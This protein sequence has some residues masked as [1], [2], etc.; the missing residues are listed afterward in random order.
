M[1]CG[2]FKATYLSDLRSFIKSKTYHS[3]NHLS[4]V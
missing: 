3:F 4:H 1:K 2:D